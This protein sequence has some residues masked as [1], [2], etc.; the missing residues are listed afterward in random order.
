[1]ATA[2]RP[3]GVRVRSARD[4]VRRCWPWDSAWDAPSWQSLPG[5][6]LLSVWWSRGGWAPVGRYVVVAG[7]GGI[8]SYFGRIGDQVWNRTGVSGLPSEVALA[9]GFC[10]PTLSRAIG[11]DD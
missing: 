7:C 2:L 4:R 1:M 6:V 11:L 10:L 9:G 8:P 3:R 5:P